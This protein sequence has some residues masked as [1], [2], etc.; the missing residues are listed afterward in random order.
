SP[1]PTGEASPEPTGEASS[2]T[3]C[4]VCGEA[5]EPEGN[6][7]PGCGEDRREPDATALAECPTCGESVTDDDHFCPSC[8][9]NLEDY[10]QEAQGEDSDDAGGAG[11]AVASGTGDGRHPETLVLRA[12]GR[13]VTVDDGDAVGREFRRILTRTGGDEEDAV[14]IHR[15]HVRFD[16][17]GGEFD[18]IDLGDNPTAVNGRPLEKG[19]RRPVGPGDTITLS[20]VLTAEVEAPQ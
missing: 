16:R 8:G 1:E 7:C 10:R 11:E 2:S 13:E 12:R 17:E 20:N 3:E 14:R 18:L 5:V 4:P 15:K 6:F 9:E 19:D